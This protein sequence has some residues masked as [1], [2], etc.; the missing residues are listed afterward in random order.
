MAVLNYSQER[1][2]KWNDPGDTGE[3]YKARLS[4]ELHP[5]VI[6]QSSSSYW[7]IFMIFTHTHTHT[8]I[9]IYIYIYIYCCLNYL[10]VVVGL[11]LTCFPNN[12][13][14]PILLPSIT[15]ETYGISDLK[16]ITVLVISQRK[17]M[18]QIQ[19]L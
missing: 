4:T 9:Y 19:Q 5:E 6:T 1:K 17:L 2:G 7:H 12:I 15:V 10:L 8:H 13:L 3:I 14:N 11:I 16:K 18:F